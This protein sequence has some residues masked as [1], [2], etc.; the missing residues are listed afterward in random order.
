[1][2]L[3]IVYMKLF[4]YENES[5]VKNLSFLVTMMQKRSR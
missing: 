2:K 5:N 4:L 1:M 3:K